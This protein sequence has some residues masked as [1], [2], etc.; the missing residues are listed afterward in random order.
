M[1]GSIAQETTWT[2]D[3]VILGFSLGST[4]YHYS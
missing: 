1:G 2:S 3:V 4:T